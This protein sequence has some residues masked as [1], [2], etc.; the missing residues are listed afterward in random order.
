MV[1]PTTLMLDD[2]CE[3]FFLHTNPGSSLWDLGYQ[4]LATDLI[5]TQEGAL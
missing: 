4:Q 2:I 5:A 1:S 3:I